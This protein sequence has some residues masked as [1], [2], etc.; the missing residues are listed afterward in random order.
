[1]SHG[2]CGII[3]MDKDVLTVADYLEKHQVL[4]N[5]K[6]TGEGPGLPAM[7]CLR[8]GK[9]RDSE[10]PHIL[11]L[12]FV[13]SS[14]SR[15]QDLLSRLLIPDLLSRA[16]IYAMLMATFAPGADSS[17]LDPARVVRRRDGLGPPL[18]Q[19]S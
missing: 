6:G 4:P 10:G 12:L 3:L 14:K 15:F 18:P 5:S 9:R 16:L 1:M 19:R 8:D 2:L 13:R 7:T 11:D 17:R